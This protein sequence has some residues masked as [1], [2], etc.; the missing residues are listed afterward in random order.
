MRPRLLPGGR[1]ALLVNG[2]D[3]QLWSLEHSTRVWVAEPPNANFRICD[4]FD[5]ELLQGGK[6]L[7]ITAGFSNPAER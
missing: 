4:T 5:F 1:Y 2:E 7:I 6:V 3:L